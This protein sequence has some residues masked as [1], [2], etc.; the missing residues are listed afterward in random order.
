MVLKCVETKKIKNP[1]IMAD[2]MFNNFSYLTEFPHLSHN[3]KELKKILKLEDNLCFL[4]Y[5]NDKLVA[6]LVGDFKTLNDSRFVYYIS[7]FYVLENYRGNGLGSQILKMV[8]NRCKKLGMAFVLLTCDTY[9]P[10]VVNFYKKHGFVKD[11]ILGTLASE[12]HMV[13][14]L[15]L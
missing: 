7:Y 2:I 1:E 3:K 6:Y 13:M 10:K 14:C 15:Y 8:I 5:D 9:D 12:R 11:P 4:V